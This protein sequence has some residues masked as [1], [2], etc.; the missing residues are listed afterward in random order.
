MEV[1]PRKY[2]HT[3]NNKWLATDSWHRW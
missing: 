1:L 3:H 2:N